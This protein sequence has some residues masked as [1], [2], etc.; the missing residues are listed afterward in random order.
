MGTFFLGL[1]F[2]VIFQFAVVG[3]IIGAL[4]RILIPGPNPMTWGK[5][6]AVGITGSFLGGIIANILGV[7]NLFS[8]LIQIS[9]AAAIIVY[10]E[11]R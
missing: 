8:T 2:I 10:L 3:L 1:T 9:S 6:A 11:R 5:T 7:E 4:A